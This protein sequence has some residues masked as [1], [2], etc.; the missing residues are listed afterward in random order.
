MRDATRRG[1]VP[2]FP[3]NQPPGFE[4]A[5]SMAA[6]KRLASSRPRSSSSICPERRTDPIS[7]VTL[8]QAGV[9]PSR[10]NPRRDGVHA[11]CSLSTPCSCALICVITRGHRILLSS[12][13]V[14]GS[15]A[16]AQTMSAVLAM[17]TTRPPPARDRARLAHRLTRV[18]GRPSRWCAQ[19][20]IRSS[21]D[22]GSP[23]PEGRCRSPPSAGKRLHAVDA[24]RD[25]VAGPIAQ[26]VLAERL[27]VAKRRAG[28]EHA[29]GLARSCRR[30][31]PSAP[32]RR[33]P[34]GAA[35]SGRARR[36]RCA[37]SSRWVLM[38]MN[39]TSGVSGMTQER[40]SAETRLGDSPASSAGSRSRAGR[41]P[42]RRSRPPDAIRG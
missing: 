19:L 14:A 10:G 39:A 42:T 2:L 29:H 20:R 16:E 22:R 35:C 8:R 34:S 11:D 18:T 25:D 31:R 15:T 26:L 12:E 32:S 3:S 36:A 23:R 27:R 40:H 9:A 5:D 21:E 7:Q 28:V 13:L 38:L 17:A 30:R 41:D 33:S 24:R 1:T 6:T 37:R 4:V